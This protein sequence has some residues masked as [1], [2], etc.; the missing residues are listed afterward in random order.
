VRTEANRREE[1]EERILKP[2]YF[3]KWFEET[4]VIAFPMSRT[5]RLY[6]AI[7]HSMSNHPFRVRVRP[8]HPIPESRQ[9]AGSTSGTAAAPPH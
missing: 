7:S 4:G 1:A 3:P 5:S 9:R 2:H 8:I 6:M